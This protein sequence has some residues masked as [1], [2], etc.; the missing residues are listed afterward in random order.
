[1]AEFNLALMLYFLSILEIKNHS[2]V[3]S[4]F[5]SVDV[6]FEFAHFYFYILA[7]VAWPATSRRCGTSWPKRTKW[8]RR[9][10]STNKALTGAPHPNN[11]TLLIKQCANEYVE[12]RILDGVMFNK[13]VTH[14][15]GGTTHL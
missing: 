15:K 4:E 2:K 12:S 8:T 10:T 7:I 9:R 6:M 3:L 5:L 11:K 13:D 1:M 14:P